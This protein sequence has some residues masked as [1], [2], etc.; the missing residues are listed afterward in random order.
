[1]DYGQLDYYGYNFLIHINIVNFIEVT[2]IFRNF[3][4]NTKLLQSRTKILECDW[5]E[6]RIYQKIQD[7]CVK[8]E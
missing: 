8:L 6:K 7:F 5:S 2:K 1:M 3:Y 4:K